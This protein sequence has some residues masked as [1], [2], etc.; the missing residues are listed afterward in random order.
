MGMVRCNVP[1][2]FVHGGSALPGQMRGRGR[3]RPERGGH[4]RDG[5]Q[6]AGRHDATLDELA[7]ITPRPA[8]PRPA[9]APGSS[10]P[11]PWAWCPR[12]SAWRPFGSEHG[13]GGVQRARAAACAARLQDT[14]GVR[15]MG[16]GPPCRATSSRVKALENACA[17]RVGHRRLHQRRACTSPPS[18]TRPASPFTSTTWRRSVCAHAAH[19]R[20]DAPAARYLARDVHSRG[21]RWRG[22]PARAAARRLSCT[23]T[24]S[25]SPAARIAARDGAS[26]NATPT[27]DV[28]RTLHEPRSAATAGWPCSRATCAPTAR[29][30]RR[31]ASPRSCTA[32]RRACLKSEE[33][34]QAAVRQTAATPPAT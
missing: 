15:S 3:A 25:P 4:L 11:T 9:P 29:S 23:A 34:A 20:P 6:G 10:P 32:A 13:A 16:D 21:R 14:D 24:R 17:H 18:R 30:S 22:H 27:A 19:R 8:C 5:R 7:A 28:V 26:A 12:P 2:V 33:A 31:P 1:S